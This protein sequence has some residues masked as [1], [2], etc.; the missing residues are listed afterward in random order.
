MYEWNE[1]FIS[2]SRGLRGGSFVN[3]S[4]YLA[5]SYRFDCFPTFENSSLGFRVAN[6]PE[7]GS[8]TML[9]AGALGVLVWRRRRNA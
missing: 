6:V 4:G 2:P 1:A 7:P 9:L 5:A 8:I 3:G